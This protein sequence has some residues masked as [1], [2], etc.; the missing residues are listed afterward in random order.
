MKDIDKILEMLNWNNNT[1]VQ[2]EGLMLAKEVECI[3]SFFQPVSKNVGKNQW[4]NCAKVIFDREDDELKSYLVKMYMWLK[5][6]NWP[7]AT[8]IAKRIYNFKDKK[9]KLNIEEKMKTIAKSL[10]DDDWLYYLEHYDEFIDT[11]IY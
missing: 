2:K 8:I 10:N 4:E 3:N 11:K 5:D 6:I 7:G 9:T 1:E